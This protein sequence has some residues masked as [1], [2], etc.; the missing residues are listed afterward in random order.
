MST[1]I[2]VLSWVGNKITK[3][4]LFYAGLIIVG[5]SLIGMFS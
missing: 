4:Q 2:S 1:I 3:K 5:V